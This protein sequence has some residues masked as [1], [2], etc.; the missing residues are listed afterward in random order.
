MRALIVAVCVVACG[1][2]LRGAND[3]RNPRVA[4]FAGELARA[5]Q[6]RDI[7]GIRAMLRESVT[8]GG[9]WFDDTSCMKQFA[10]AGEIRGPRLDE[11]ARCLTTLQL[12]T[13]TRSDAL[14]D[15]VLMTYRPGIELEARFVDGEDGPWLAWIGY[16]ARRDLQDALPTV[17][18]A[19]LEPLRVAG[20][21]KAPLAGPGAF[22]DLEMSKYAY[23]WLKICIDGAGTITGAHV[24]EASSPRAARTFSAAIQTW[25]F[26]PF[27]LGTQPTPVC[28][29]VRM[30]YP[31]DRAPAKEMLPLPVPDNPGPVLNVPPIRLGERTAGRTAIP[32][33]DMDKLRVQQSRVRTLIAALHYCIDET[34]RVSRVTLI[35]SSGL[36]GYDRKL[37]NEAK[38][39][40]FKPFLDEGKPIPVC[41][42]THFIYTQSG[43]G[44]RVN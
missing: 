14:P 35:R 2:G 1:P 28:S 22:D 37:V 7:A 20:D 24:R 40:A 38:A 43:R 13:S 34:G 3:Y 10:A 6:Q 33:D 5:S 19:A 17:S 12:T 11:L 44:V 41:S 21:A 18:P 27:V 30:T 32:P 42:S 25:Q 9:L 15:V 39:W 23:A 36:P 16:V 29:M 8:I 4:D 31:A 26:R